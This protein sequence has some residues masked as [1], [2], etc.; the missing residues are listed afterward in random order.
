[1]ISKEKVAL[2]TGGISGI[3]A[4]IAITLSKHGY[5]VV[6]NYPSFMSNV[7][8]T[9]KLKNNIDTIEF[10]ASSFDASKTAFEH[11]SAKHGH[12]DILINNA[13]ITKDT[14]LH[15]MSFEEWKSVLNV[16]LDSVFN[17]SRH[18]IEIMRKKEYGRIINISS[19]NA[20][21]GQIG[22]TNY[23]ASKA[24]IIGFTKALALESASKGITVN[25]IAPGY[26]N[27]EM[28][29]KINK[30]IVE[31]KI[32]PKIPQGRYAHPSEIASLVTYLISDSAS[33]ITGQTISINGG[34]FFS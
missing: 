12:I 26:V 2:I 1:M 25:A 15:K 16:N 17:C 27:T 20:L 22:Q 18:A 10:D 28:T 32:L 6:A 30:D 34:M 5:K 29:Q 7:A 8:Q 9:F 13:G 23:C 33:Y 14:F 31:N 4:E 11:M 19:V 21:Q 3:G 24:A